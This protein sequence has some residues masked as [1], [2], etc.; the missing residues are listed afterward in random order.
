MD[1]VVENPWGASKMEHRERTNRSIPL[2]ASLVLLAA[3]LWAA[4]AR[5]ADAREPF[6]YAGQPVHPACVH[7]L[8]MHQ[9]DRMP[10]T[11]AV[12]LEG[13]AASERSVPSSIRP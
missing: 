4:L 8:A 2:R 5:E 11:T 10:V 12:S 9:G 13:C 7:A 6:L 3:L 1:T